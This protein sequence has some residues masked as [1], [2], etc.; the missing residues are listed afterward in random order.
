MGKDPN[1]PKKPLTAYFRYVATIRKEV[2]NETGLTGIKLAP[3]LAKRWKEVS[4]EEKAPFQAPIKAEMEEWKK[5]VKAY[6]KT[7]SYYDHQE[8]STKKKF[9]KQ[10]KDKNAPKR[11][12]TSF[13]LYA[14]SVRAQV[15]EELG[16][17][18]VAV[19]GKKIGEMWKALSAEEKASWIE[20]QKK[21]KE[22]YNALLE[23]YKKTEEFAAH[24]AAV[25]KFGVNKKKAYKSLAKLRKEMGI[26]N[27]N[28]Q[29]VAAEPIEDEAD[30]S[31]SMEE[32]SN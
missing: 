2:Q 21:E 18:S 24:K 19:V 20:K 14:G 12:M 28:D 7:R 27:A 16:A 10:P 1:C 15:T 30:D 4:A 8:Q 11:A 13:F 17:K 31:E 29:K 5:K 26:T 22:K 23:E 3:H 6:K 32:E 9:K 25:T